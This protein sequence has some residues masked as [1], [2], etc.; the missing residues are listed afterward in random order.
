MAVAGHAAGLLLC[1]ALGLD[2]SSVQGIRIECN[3][4]EPVRVFVRGIASISD[5]DR[6]D[7]ALRKIDRKEIHILEEGSMN[8]VDRY[9]SQIPEHVR[10]AI[11]KRILNT[12]AS[13]AS[14]AET[15]VSVPVPAVAAPVAA[16]DAAKEDDE[17]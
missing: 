16:S 14:V 17:A 13:R 9:W 8:E 2:A 10:E 4:K 7:S 5:V 3:V 1:E 12:P 6:L 15:I 11:V